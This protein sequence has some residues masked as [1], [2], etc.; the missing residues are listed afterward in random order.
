MVTSP[1]F[2]FA[3][4]PNGALH[5]GHA[6][7]ALLNFRLAHSQHGRF[8]LR[9]ED[10]D[11]ERCTPAFEKAIY[12]DL[13]WLGIQWEHPVRRQSEHFSDYDAVLKKLIRE[14]LVYPA[15]MSRGDIRAY[16]SETADHGKSWPRDPDGVPHYPPIDRRLS[17]RERRKRMASGAPFAWRLDVKGALARI[18]QPIDWTE[19]LDESLA[20]SENIDARPES[21]GDI[22][23]ARKDIPTSYHLA[24][25]LDDARQS[26]THIVRGR[27]LF[28]ATSIQ[29]LLQELLNL[30]KPSY[31]H[32]RLVL[33]ENGR[34]LSKSESDT[35]LGKLRAAGATVEDVMRLIGLGA[36]Q[37][38]G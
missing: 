25:V 22:V 15:F 6:L 37:E 28:H 7:S 27:D 16:I 35:G 19:F 3:P 9:I 10:I 8:L 21:W 1:V 11:V 18:S 26:V 17:A 31:F 12:D 14:N 34:K 32:H 20:H 13:N 23:L 24:V 4:S 29:R 30:P 2:R 33:D 5:L 38:L 36:G